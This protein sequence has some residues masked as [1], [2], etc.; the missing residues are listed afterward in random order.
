MK[1]QT[2]LKQEE[3]PEDWK[4]RKLSELMEIIGGGTPKTA[5]KG[6]WDGDI[7]WLSVTDFN[8][9]RRYVY[10]TEKKITKEGLE[11]SSTKIL[12]KGMLIISARGTVGEIAQLAKDMT[13]NQSCY[14]L[15]AKKESTN[16]FLFYLIKYHL[17]KLKNHS[18]GSVFDTITT[19]TFD[20]IPIRLPSLKEQ[21][22]IVKILSDLDVKIEL[23]QKMD[24]TLESIGQ[25]LF[26]HWFFDREDTTKNWQTKQLDEIAE[27]LNGIALQKYPAQEGEEFLPVI[28]IRELRSGITNQTD[29]ANLDLPEEYMIIN[30]D[31]LF[32]WSGSLEVVLWCN[33][34][35]ALNQHLFK[36]SSDKYPKWFYYHWIKEFLPEF[37]K[38]AEGKATTMGHIQRHH[39]SDSKVIV[40]D[41]ISLQKM[42]KIMKPLLEKIISLK[43]QSN[44]LS[45]IRDSLLPQLMS[46]KIRVSFE[47]GKDRKK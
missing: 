14:G 9:G 24:K 39:L 46:G 33:G 23:N 28:K 27:F 19:K 32:S 34:A 29:K 47:N 6:Y 12:K 7:C 13:F 3:I 5:N 35:G 43:I 40:P 16:D 22:A 15:N 8:N 1:Q 36:V 41:E 30:G 31:V 37:R 42:N 21:Q 17:T 44:N 18:Y 25:A 26:K 38:I 10:D 4:E 2:K 11:N 20:E 45:Q